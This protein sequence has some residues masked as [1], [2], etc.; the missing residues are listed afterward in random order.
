M[1]VFDI[2]CPC[3][4]QLSQTGHILHLGPTLAKLLGDQQALPVRFLELF[5]MRRSHPAA[6]MKVLFA[7]AGQKLTFRLRAAPHTELKAVLA[8]MRGR[9]ASFEGAQKN[10]PHRQKRNNPIKQQSYPVNQSAPRLRPRISARNPRKKSTS[11]R[12]SGRAKNQNALEAI[13]NKLS[14]SL[15]RCG[16]LCAKDN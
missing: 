9:K 3:H 2:L 12:F 1:S 11:G 4:A 16:E 6:T 15:C 14:I 8:L 13:K 7:L 5:E 10:I